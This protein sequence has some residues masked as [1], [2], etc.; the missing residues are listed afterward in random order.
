MSDTA[1]GQTPPLYKDAGEKWANFFVLFYI[2]RERDSGESAEC[3]RTFGLLFMTVTLAWMREVCQGGKGKKAVL[4]G[5]FGE[6]QIVP[7]KHA[8]FSV[9]IEK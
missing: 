5:D 9:I 8:H 4:T 1:F 6:A 2:K 3:W 7:L